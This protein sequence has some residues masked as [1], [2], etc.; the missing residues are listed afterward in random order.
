MSMRVYSHIVQRKKET[1]VDQPP[2]LPEQ[3]HTALGHH[4]AHKYMYVG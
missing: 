3:P 4:T 1:F 2:I